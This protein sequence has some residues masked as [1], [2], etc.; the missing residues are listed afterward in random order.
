MDGYGDDHQE[1]LGHGVQLVSVGEVLLLQ[2]SK[3]VRQKGS[4]ALRVWVGAEVAVDEV[5]DGVGDVEEALQDVADAIGASQAA[6]QGNQGSPPI[7]PSLT[8]HLHMMR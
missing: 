5:D 4:G 1:S 6:Q 8:N 2:P 3:L 7:L